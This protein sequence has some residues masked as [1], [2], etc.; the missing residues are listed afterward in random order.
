M[1]QSSPLLARG[2]QGYTDIEVKASPA[3]IIDN[4]ARCRLYFNSSPPIV[5]CCRCAVPAPCAIMLDVNGLEGHISDTTYVHADANVNLGSM[6]SNTMNAAGNPNDHPN[7]HGALVH[8]IN[9]L[10]N[11]NVAME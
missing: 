7:K 6:I 2:S 11:E 1:L 10:P 5:L 8:K 9:E 4:I 3:D